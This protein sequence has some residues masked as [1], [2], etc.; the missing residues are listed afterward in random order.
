MA[1]EL[2]REAASIADLGCL[3]F[4]LVLRLAAAASRSSSTRNLFCSAAQNV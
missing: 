3:A 2:A 1:S 4:A